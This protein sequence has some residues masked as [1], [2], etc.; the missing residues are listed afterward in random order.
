M[1][2]A[3]GNRQVAQLPDR[4]A[5]SFAKNFTAE[6][7]SLQRAYPIYGRLRHIFDLAVVMEIVRAQAPQTSIPT[8]EVLGKQAF[9]PHMEVAPTQIDSIVATRK[10]SDGSVSAIVSGGVSIEPKVVRS[11]LRLDRELK[12]RVSL[13]RSPGEEQSPE[14][15]LGLEVPF[16]K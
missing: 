8:F 12:N 14:S 3:D 16:W 11:K 4:A 15:Q 2:T 13:E 6:F 7:Q 5:D 10:R 9:V 1:M